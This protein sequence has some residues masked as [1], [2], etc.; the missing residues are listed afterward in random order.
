MSELARE[1][2]ALADIHWRAG[3]L[4]QASCCHAHAIIIEARAAGEAW[5]DWPSADAIS[6]VDEPRLTRSM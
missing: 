6:A 2:R 5:I 4:Q 1:L 3:N